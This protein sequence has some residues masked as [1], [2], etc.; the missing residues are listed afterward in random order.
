MKNTKEKSKAK[1]RRF[2]MKTD[3]FCFVN[4]CHNLKALFIPWL[5]A[6]ILTGVASTG[7][8]FFS[9]E[10]D[11]V[12]AT[13]SFHYVG[14]ENGLDPN[15]CDFDKDDI[16]GSQIIS[17]ALEAEGLSAELLEPIRENIH[18]GSVVSTNAISSIINH[19]SIFASD[20]VSW[21]QDISD[22]SYYPT[23]FV[24]SLNYSQTDLSG[25]QAASLLNTML[26]KYSEYFLEIYG[27]NESVGDQLKSADFENYDY[28]IALDMLS[29]D[30]SSL[31][32][33]IK[34]LDSGDTTDFRSAETGYSFSDLSDS[35]NLIRTVDIDTLTSYVLN[36][37]VIN[38]KSSIL[39]YYNYRIDNLKRYNKIYE[40]RLEE[41]ISSIESYKKDSIIVYDGLDTGTAISNTTDVYDKLIQE[42]IQL[43]DT[44][45]AN[46]KTISDL[47]ERVSIIKKTSAGAA[48]ADKEYVDKKI[49]GLQEKTSKLAD[50]VKTTAD[51]FFSTRKYHNAM[52]VTSAASYSATQL[53][54][55]AINESIRMIIICELILLIVYLLAAIYFC[56]HDKLKR[57]KRTSEK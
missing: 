56:M 18:I 13:V 32:T 42:K 19:D 38:D 14:I 33:Y 7:L 57:M 54:K 44:I 6:A 39:S 4:L 41:T 51:E 17:A 2:S 11:A 23:R 9:A 53:L 24:I 10:V 52:T 45:S 15:G 40:Y 1:K 16:A 43:Q 27:Y 26:E 20:S 28:L 37:G 21:V 25:D 5:I 31:E 30:L 50:S 8:H 34:T 36:N 12:T 3:G 22:T 29:S 48:K 49:A 47:E 46:K 55:A 35:A